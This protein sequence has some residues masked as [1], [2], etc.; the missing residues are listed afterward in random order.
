MFFVRNV[1]G[2]YIKGFA[3][4][5]DSDEEDDFDGHPYGII[6]PLDPDYMKFADYFHI[7]FGPEM[8][9]RGIYWEMKGIGGQEYHGSGF[10]IR[11]NPNNKIQRKELPKIG[12]HEVA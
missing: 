12:C 6:T 5:E 8:E 2:K 11:F 1:I 7:I 9:E 3:N 4:C 10:L